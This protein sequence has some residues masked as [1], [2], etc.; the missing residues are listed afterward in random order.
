MV[1]FFFVLSGFFIRYAQQKKF[2][3]ALSFYLNRVVRIYPPYLASLVLAGAALVYVAY[4]HPALLA[5]TAGREYNADLWVA[6][7][8]LYPMTMSRLG[9]TLLFLKSGD[10]YFGNNGVYWSLL[11]EALFYASVPLAFWRIRYY[12][13]ISTALYACG[14]AL[15]AL[16]FG[17]GPL[18]KFVFVYN[19]YFALGVGL[20]DVVS[21]RPRWLAVF[22]QV[23]G[24]WLTI[25]FALLNLSLVGTAVAHFTIL[26]GPLAALL[27]VLSV[28]VLLA[29]RVNRRNFLVRV[30]HEVGLFSF[31]LYLYHPPLLLL[32]YAGLVASTGLLVNFDHYYWAAVPLVTLGCYALYFVTERLAVRFF[33][34]I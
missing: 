9:K 11:P 12:Y 18:G 28:S 14:I 23:K 5:T 33:R 15:E 21:Q 17:T 8:E 24:V 6:W 13:A 27:A 4:Q 25:A 20:F 30:F 34:G 1:I 26:S 31:S 10:K 19:G 7:H 3:P 32:V 22:E 29:G 16:H 2:R